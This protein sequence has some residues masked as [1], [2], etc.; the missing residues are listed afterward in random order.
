MSWLADLLGNLLQ[1][2]GSNFARRRTWNWLYGPTVTDDAAN[3]RLNHDFT[4]IR[5]QKRELDIA[6]ADLVAIFTSQPFNLDDPLP[7]NAHVLGVEVELSETFTG[8]GA[9]YVQADVGSSGDQDAIANNCDLYAAPV[10]GQCS[11]IVAGIAPNKSFAA[12]TQLTVLVSS[13]VAL[14][15]ITTGSCTIRVLFAEIPW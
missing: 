11:R 15:G 5:V 1:V 4:N 13:N 12:A 7:A 8:G 3:G 9:T 14:N 2:A 6:H 10:D